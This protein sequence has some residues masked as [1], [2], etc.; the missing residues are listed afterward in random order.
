MYNGSV[1]W[2]FP[3]E[4][5]N[6]IYKDL[7]TPLAVKLGASFLRFNDFLALQSTA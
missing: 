7:L 3:A 2:Q 1:P 4:L 6:F 5:G